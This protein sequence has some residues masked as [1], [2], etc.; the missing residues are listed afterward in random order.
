M[1]RSE[2]VFRNSGIVNPKLRE[3]DGLT[4]LLSLQLGS[5]CVFLATTHFT[6]TINHS[7]YKRDEQK[8]KKKCCLLSCLLVLRIP[9]EIIYVS[10][11]AILKM[12]ANTRLHT[13]PSFGL[14]T[15]TH[16][17]PSGFPWHSSWMW[18]MCDRRRCETFR[19]RLAHTTKPD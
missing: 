13:R 10:L 11:N 4:S 18:P 9:G 7:H 19:I 17:Q 14:H 1:W 6:L 5:G 12:A 2:A 16:T 15:H 8:K 3:P